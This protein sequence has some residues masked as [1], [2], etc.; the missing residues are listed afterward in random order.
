MI[1]ILSI[2]FLSLSVLSNKVNILCLWGRTTRK[3]LICVHQTVLWFSDTKYK[4]AHLIT[5]SSTSS[6]SFNCLIID[7]LKRNNLMIKWTQYPLD[8][9]RRFL[10]KN[11]CFK[12]RNVPQ[13]I[14][15]SFNFTSD[16]FRGLFFFFRK[17]SIM[18]TIEI[19]TTTSQTIRTQKR[20]EHVA[21]PNC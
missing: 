2:F 10:S 21:V 11:S 13:I 5:S 9:H 19:Q 4:Y 7:C 15:F 12:I 8:L 3:F 14:I 6:S 1:L 17:K 18:Q 20:R 16:K